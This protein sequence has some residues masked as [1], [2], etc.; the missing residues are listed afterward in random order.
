MVKQNERGQ[1]THSQGEMG[2]N[3]PLPE[4]VGKRS[5]NDL[6]TNIKII[7]FQFSALIEMQL[8]SWYKM[9][10]NIHFITDCHLYIDRVWFEN[11]N[12]VVSEVESGLE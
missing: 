2:E 6:G 1:N 8:I 11:S 4:N 10:I 7:V 12:E 3:T 9:S 5:L